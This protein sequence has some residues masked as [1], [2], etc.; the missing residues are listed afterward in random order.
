MNISLIAR[1]GA[2]AALAALLLAGCSG[3]GSK[4]MSSVNSTVDSVGSVFES[5][6]DESSKPAPPP[7]PRYCYRTIGKVQCYAQPLSASESNR[8][9][10]YDGPPPRAT[11][12]TGPLSQ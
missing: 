10:G 9:V 6:E 3:V 11:S 4:I 7:S 1:N 2:A 8:L 12:G 5:S